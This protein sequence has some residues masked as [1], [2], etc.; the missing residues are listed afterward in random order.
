MKV[1]IRRLRMVAGAAAGAGLY[2]GMATG[3]VSVDL[4]VGRRRRPLGPLEVR[5]HAPPEVVFDVIAAPYLHPTPRA[6]AQKLRVLE[7][8]T[9]LVLA[10][11]YTPVR[12]GL[13]T[14]T[15]ETVRFNRPHRIDFRLTRGPVPSVVETFELRAD[16]DGTTLRYSGELQTD[17][18]RLGAF[19]GHI[20]A[21]RWVA[22]VEASLSS[23]K[24]EAERR[25]RLGS[26]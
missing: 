24:A 16:G 17:L 11:H 26:L 21:N 3:R 6:M 8:G 2:I 25:A 23:T 9:D 7:R 1:P 22:A 20:V 4:G 12:W 13:R 19:W 5:F 15:V 10:E 14:T 18:W